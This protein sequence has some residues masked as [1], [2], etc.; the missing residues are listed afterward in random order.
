MKRQHAA[1]AGAM[2]TA[3]VIGVVW[4]VWLKWSETP[5]PKRKLTQGSLATYHS[6]LQEYHLEHGDYPNTLEGSAISQNIVSPLRN[7]GWGNPMIYS[8]ISKDE[9]LLYSAGPDGARGT[10]DDISE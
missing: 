7:D 4:M 2:V 1:L 3:G 6:L 5:P 8:R 9:Y 10:K